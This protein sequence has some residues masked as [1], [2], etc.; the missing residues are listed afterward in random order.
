MYGWGLQP[1]SKIYSRLLD[2]N[3]R[4]DLCPEEKFY[5]MLEATQEND[6]LLD[7]AMGPNQGQGVPAPEDSDGLAWD[8]FP[9]NTTVPIGGSFA[10]IIPGWGTGQLHSVT[11]ALVTDSVNIT[12]PASQLA[13]LVEFGTP[14]SLPN[15]E[16]FNRT[17]NTLSAES[18]TVVTDLVGPDGSLN[19][20]FAGNVTGLYYTIFVTYLIHSH[21]RA[22]VSALET[23]PPGTPAPTWLQNGSWAVDHYSTTGANTMIGFWETYL[24]DNATKTLLEAVG[25][26][27]WED[28]IE[29]E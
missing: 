11:T 19:I 12:I 2:W 7:F 24:L 18:L 15:D 16:P 1:W 13:A 22:Q 21:W 5:T 28:S 25:N 20:T 6:L 17:Q 10:D 9:F 27:G 4:T 23:D 29:I 14:P 3:Y 26:Y 8:L